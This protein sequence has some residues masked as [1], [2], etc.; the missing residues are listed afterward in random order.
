MIFLDN[1]KIGN[2]IK[3]LRKKKKMTQK[4]LADKLGI[5]DRA[6]SRWERGIGCP[7]ISLLESLADI[8]G[9]SV[10]ELLKGEY[11]DDEKEIDEGSLLETMKLSRNNVI[12]KIKRW[13]NYLTV[14]VVIVI[15]LFIVITNIKS[16]YLLNK[17]YDMDIYNI[18]DDSA[19]IIKEFNNK[20]EI[21]MNNQGKY[22][23]RDYSRI[24]SSMKIMKERLAE[25]NNKKYLGKKKYSY[26]DLVQ[27]YVDHGNLRTMEIDNMDIYRILVDYDG[28]VSDNM[29]RYEFDDQRIKE[30]ISYMFFALEEPYFMS[31]DSYQYIGN[32]DSI[33]RVIYEREIRL[34]DDI[35]KVGGLG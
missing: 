14:L 11:I 2:F 6:V 16:V 17:S 35:I 15:C 13:Y 27:F 33:V 22:E 19:D 1:I 20:V 24:R 25:Q 32:I 23:D 30:N 8:L 26:I 10:L 4:E 21:I 5:T 28:G 29:V 34:C 9:V 12:Y 7:D 31:N 3:L 18:E